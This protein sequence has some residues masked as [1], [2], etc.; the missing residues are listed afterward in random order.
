MRPPLSRNV[1]RWQSGE[2]CLR[3]TATGTVKAERQFRRIIGYDGINK[4]ALA[5]EAEIAQPT[6]THVAEEAATPITI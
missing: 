6:A 1:K 5:V 3:W 4:F 2:M